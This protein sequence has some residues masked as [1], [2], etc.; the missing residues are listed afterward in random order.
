MIKMQQQKGMRSR[1]LFKQP[2]FSLFHDK[3][4]FL[5][6]ILLNDMVF[7]VFS[8]PF[9]LSTFLG[10]SFTSFLF[11]LI[12]NFYSTLFISCLIGRIFQS[13]IHPLANNSVIILE[14][15]LVN[16]SIIYVEKTD[17][18]AKQVKYLN[19]MKKAMLNIIIKMAD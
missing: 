6:L 4:S 18:R 13:H 2:I 3:I 11:A 5:V 15:S 16:F 19:Y 10:V 14:V 8:S 17:C 12:V 7:S 1:G 9:Q